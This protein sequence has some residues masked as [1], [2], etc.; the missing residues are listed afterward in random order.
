MRLDRKTRAEIAGRSIAGLA[1]YK[2]SDGHRLHPDAIAQEIRRRVEE[3]QKAPSE[4][5]EARPEAG[6]PGSGQGQQVT[7]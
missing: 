3:K 4:S 6:Q 2:N 1:R 7:P 5:A